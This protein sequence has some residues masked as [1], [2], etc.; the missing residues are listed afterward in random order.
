MATRALSPSL[1]WPSGEDTPTKAIAIKVELFAQFLKAHAF[2]FVRDPK[3]L[4]QIVHL[5]LV[6]NPPAVPGR[7]ISIDLNPI[8]RRSRWSFAHVTKE[9]IKRF[10]L[11]A[12][13][14][15]APSIQRIVAVLRIVAPLPHAVPALVSRALRLATVAV[16]T[17]HRARPAS[18]RAI[19]ATSRF[20]RCRVH[21]P[22][23]P[24]AVQTAH[25]VRVASCETHFNECQHG[26]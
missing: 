5:P 25:S 11:G 19:P 13:S 17:E 22:N 4:S 9:A 16:P 15:A 21:M 10:P 7:I 24:S 6:R 18:V 14:D 8:Q 3:R 23:R 2:A 20:P 12:D 1:L 26:D